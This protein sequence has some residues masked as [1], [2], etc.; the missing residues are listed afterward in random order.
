[1][2]GKKANI[3][4]V[5]RKVILHVRKQ[6]RNV[7]TTELDESWRLIEKQ[8]HATKKEKLHNRLLYAATYSSVA[9]QSCYVCFGWVNSSSLITMQM[10]AH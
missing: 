5:I 1:M 10:T 7:S 4:Q 9:S 2:E 3:H 8:I 6:E